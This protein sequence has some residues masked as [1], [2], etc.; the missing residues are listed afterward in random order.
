M[1]LVE[2]IG[3]DKEVQQLNSLLEE[4][5]RVAIVG[6]GGL[7]KTTLA[8]HCGYHWADQGNKTVVLNSETQESIVNSLRGLAAELRIEDFR[9][10]PPGALTQNI[11]KILKNFPVLII[12]DNVDRF[13]TVRDYLPQNSDKNFYI[14][15][16]SQNQNHAYFNILRLETLNEEE[17]TTLIRNKVSRKL[18]NTEEQSADV[19]ALI[20]VSQGLPLALLQMISYIN[21]KYKSSP[22]YTIRSYLEKHQDNLLDAKRKQP[23]LDDSLDPYKNTVYRA[24]LMNVELMETDDDFIEIMS[25]ILHTMS[26]LNPTEIR[27]DFLMQLCQVDEDVFNDFIFISNKY[28]LTEQTVRWNGTYLNVHRLVLEVIGKLVDAAGQDYKSNIAMDTMKFIINGNKNYWEW[29]LHRDFIS[30][31]M[32]VELFYKI[33]VPLLREKLETRIKKNLASELESELNSSKNQYYSVYHFGAYLGVK[34]LFEDIRISTGKQSSE[35]KYLQE[36]Y[37]ERKSLIIGGKYK[38]CWISDVDGRVLLSL[39]EERGELELIRKL[40]SQGALALY[41]PNV[42][43]YETSDKHD[44]LK[45]FIALLDGATD[46]S[47]SYDKT[48][49]Y[50]A[51]NEVKIKYV[52][53]LLSKGGKVTIADEQ[54]STPLHIVARAGSVEWVRI[55]LDNGADIDAKSVGGT[56]LHMAAQEGDV[57]CIKMLLDNDANVNSVDSDGQTPLHIAVQTGTVESLNIL[58]NNGADVNTVNTFGWTPLHVAVLEDNPES[59]SVLLNHGAVVNVKNKSGETP[60]DISKLFNNSECIRLLTEGKNNNPV[61]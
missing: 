1:N 29:D 13:S 46:T 45:Y 14:I 47:K 56:P 16:T 25:K 35:I 53:A 51:D 37:M 57:E 17:A 9:D 6:M 42:M 59:I 33:C 8:F 60:L 5:R 7:G 50:D 20:S 32:S 26:F 10:K 54:G 44:M 49:L 4:H 2:M 48:L 18:W 11:W 19:K 43:F 12:Y 31:K 58:L 52:S 3:R 22:N 21:F 40:I 61:V 23:Y 28:S 34:N 39:A 36:I 38:T 41:A 55:L 15:I 30:R 27:R 24:V